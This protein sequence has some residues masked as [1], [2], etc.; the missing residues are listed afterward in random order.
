[1]ASQPVAIRFLER[2]CAAAERVQAC[3]R[4]IG[5]DGGLEEPRC[6]A[7]RELTQRGDQGCSQTELADALGLAESSL[8]GLVDRMQQEGLL[9]RFRSKS[10]RRKSLLMPTHAGRQRY[11]QVTAA[12]ETLVS[13]WLADSPDDEL[14]LIGSWL[15]GL[16]SPETAD[17]AAPGSPADRE[18]LRPNP[19][20]ASVPRG[21]DCWKEA[22]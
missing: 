20:A 11:H 14:E 5:E 13:S 7:I 18:A 12:F 2:L 1:M 10:D 22:G 4:R 16:A 21:G 8:C 6:H 19:P 15:D 17:A 3:R 9:H